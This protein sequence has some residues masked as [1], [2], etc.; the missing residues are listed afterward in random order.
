MEGIN[1]PYF[2]TYWFA[3]ELNISQVEGE[4]A[5]MPFIKRIVL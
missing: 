5:P 4:T 1:S 2:Y 3:E